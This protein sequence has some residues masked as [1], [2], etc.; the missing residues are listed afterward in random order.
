VNVLLGAKLPEAQSLRRSYAAVSA[1]LA[2]AGLGLVL[3][4]R[5]AA[6]GRTGLAGAAVSGSLGAGLLFGWPLLNGLSWGTTLRLLPDLSAGVLVLGLGLLL[7]A[8]IAA[9][10][11][12]G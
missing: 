1:A 9:G 5:R 12:R 3:L 10:K 4:I 11:G 6:Q 7:V 8:G 2:V